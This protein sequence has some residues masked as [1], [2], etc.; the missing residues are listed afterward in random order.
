MV[1]YTARELKIVIPQWNRARRKNRIL[2]LV[3]GNFDKAFFSSF[4][5]SSRDVF[6]VL[7]LDHEKGRS[8]KED[9]ISFVN[10]SEQS[11][12][13]FV[14]SDFDY[15]VDM[16]QDDIEKVRPYG[17]QILDT[18]KCTDLNM[19]IISK[20]NLEDYLQK[21]ISDKSK[22]EQIVQV[23]RI[24]G[25]IRFYKRHYERKNPG[26]ILHLKLSS[27]HEAL[28]ERPNKCSINDIRSILSRKSSN[29]SNN[30]FFFNKITEEKIN[31]TLVRFTNNKLDI[32]SFVN[33]HDITKL[34]K[35]IGG[36]EKRNIETEL[37]KIGE[38][39]ENLCKEI[40]SRLIS[41]S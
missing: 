4:L 34:M 9:V 23:S 3:E 18:E 32:Y 2:L 5:K 20:M 36:I 26:E 6:D 15:V 35:S 21:N 12:I 29:N 27:I 13:G 17:D 24:I 40:Y 33:G 16:I 10:K 31:K 30:S 25:V 7:G 38:N 8:N 28:T 11:V 39:N 22:I 37:R 14:D 19:L 1:N 41:L